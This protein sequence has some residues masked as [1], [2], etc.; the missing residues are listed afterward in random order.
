AVGGTPRPL[1]RGGGDLDPGG[2]AAPRP[3]ARRLPVPA[4]LRLGVRPLPDEGA[5]GALVRRHPPRVLS[6]ERAAHRSD[7][8]MSQNG[9]LLEVSDLVTRY[10]VPRGIIGTIA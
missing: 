4:A 1:R 9:V 10:P 3:R 2:A 5:A 7:R 8:R 6:P